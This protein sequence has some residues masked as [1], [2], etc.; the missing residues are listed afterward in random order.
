MD[1]ADL[2]RVGSVK[3]IDSRLLPY[4]LHARQEKGFGDAM[5]EVKDM[6]KNCTSPSES[7]LLQQELTRVSPD[8]DICF[9]SNVYA[10]ILVDSII[11]GVIVVQ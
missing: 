7:E 4:S 8:L 3:K 10:R 9:D 5:S 11:W 6:L 1:S 2:M